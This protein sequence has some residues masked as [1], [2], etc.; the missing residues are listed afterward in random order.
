MAGRGE[1]STCIRAGSS[2]YVDHNR[3]DARQLDAVLG[4]EGGTRSSDASEQVGIQGSRLRRWSWSGCLNRRLLWSR[5]HR[6]P[7]SGSGQGL[8]WRTS[9]KRRNRLRDRS[10]GGNQGYWSYD[11]RSGA[12]A[13]PCV[14]PQGTPP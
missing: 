13:L 4:G 11:C 10:L 12:G 8:Y 3:G 2:A 1:R 6:S 9:R 14:I 7:D 5:L